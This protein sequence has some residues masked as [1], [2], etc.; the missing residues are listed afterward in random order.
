MAF[1]NQEMKKKLAPGIKE[2]LKK[3][4]MKGTLAVRDHMVLVVNIKEGVL[5]FEDYEQ[6]NPYHVS[7]FYEGEKRNFLTELLAA[8]RGDMWYDNSDAMTDYFDTA[9]Y[10]NINVG[11]WNKPYKQVA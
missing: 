2:V 3:Y 7:R 1:M 11:N 10:M 5:P 4:G 6:V 9:Y 8:M